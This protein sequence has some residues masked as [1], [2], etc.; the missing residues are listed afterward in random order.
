MHLVLRHVSLVILGILTFANILVW[1]GILSRREGVLTISFLNIGQGD[2]IYIESPTGTQVVVDGGPDSS[3][4]R[5]LGAVMPFSDHSLDMIVVTNPDKDHYFGFLDVLDRYSVADELEPG[6]VSRTS[7]YRYLKKKIAEKN[8]PQIIARGGQ[9]YDLGGGAMLYILFPDRDITNWSSNEGSLVM[10]LVYG[11]TSV[12]LDGD[13]VQNIEK[14][15]VQKD[16]TA[17]GESW[18]GGETILKAGHHG[19]RTSTAPE[20]VADLKP[21]ATAISAGA[22]NKFGH[23]HKETLDTLAKAGV[24]ALVTFKEGRITFTSDGTHFTRW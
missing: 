3:I 22:G 10:D 18:Q 5:E 12:F 21:V 8:I 20:L 16:G 6:T 1:Q 19:S 24:P 7:D 4:L 13:S 15:L 9:V 2:S 14:Y 23:P 11:K 17:L